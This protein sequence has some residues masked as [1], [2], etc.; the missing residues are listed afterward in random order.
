MKDYVF[1]SVAGLSV[2]A[3]V[4]FSVRA[5][6][7][8]NKKSCAPKRKIVPEMKPAYEYRLFPVAET[9]ETAKAA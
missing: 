5:A 8:G 3:L 9:S 4:G 2:L 7:R 1:W 6:A